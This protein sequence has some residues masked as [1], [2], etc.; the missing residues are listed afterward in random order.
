MTEPMETPR[1]IGII[2]DG[3]G[4]WAQSQGFSRSVGHQKGARRAEEVIRAC[5][6]RNVP[7]LTLFTLSTENL[8]RPLAEKKALFHILRSNLNQLLQ[9][10][11]EHNL[12]V[13][14]QGEW[15]LLPPAIQKSLKRIV[16]KT[17]TVS[18]RL[19]ITLALAYGGRAELVRAAEKLAHTPALGAIPL[20]A[21]EL[22]FRSGL[23]H[24]E[25][26]DL[27]FLIRTGGEWRLS[28]FMLW[29][30]AYAELYFTEVL[31]PDFTTRHL[32]EALSAYA[33]RQRRFG[34]LAPLANQAPLH[35]ES[36][37]RECSNGL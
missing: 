23:Y 36:E 24:P 22:Q 21:L 16:T 32:D 28:N 4:R 31:W 25:H 30:A 20:N 5:V 9:E 29:Q 26:P 1:H 3:N 19:I 10:C 12:Q 17:E 13:K 8:E 14:V 35:Q 37:K 15:K 18:P 11:L 2:M 6:K 34:V 7:Y 33:L 27:D